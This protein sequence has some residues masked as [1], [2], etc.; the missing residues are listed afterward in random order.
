MP[1][2]EDQ[3]VLQQVFDDLLTA[4]GRGGP[5]SKVDKRRNVLKMDVSAFRFPNNGR[6]AL[7]FL[8]IQ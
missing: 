8:L 6:K 5:L 4:E 3:E 7:L 2:N 1:V